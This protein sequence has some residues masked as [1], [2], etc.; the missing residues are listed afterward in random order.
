MTALPRSIPR[1]ALFLWLDQLDPPETLATLT[2]KINTLP[3]TDQQKRD[4]I[5]RLNNAAEFDIDNPL[6]NT[7]AALVGITTQQQ[8]VDAINT[9]F[10][11]L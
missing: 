3:I 5:I 9:A 10:S 4:A 7:V 11:L 8:K 1:T 6:F 2:A